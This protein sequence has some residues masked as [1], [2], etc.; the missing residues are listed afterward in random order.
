L[1]WKKKK[2]QKMEKINAR[3]E[4]G[5]FVGIKRASGEVWVATPEGIMKARSVKRIPK[6]QRWGPDCLKWVKH[7]PW[8][9]YPGATDADGEIPEDKLVEASGSTGP[10]LGG[11]AGRVM[12]NVRQPPPREFY[13]RKEDG[14]KHGYTKGCSGCSS[15]FR[16]LGR[17]PHSKAC[18]DRFRELLKGEAKMKNAE[19]RKQEFE[20]KVARKAEKKEQKKEEK[21]KRKAGEGGG[22]EDESAMGIADDAEGM[23]RVKKEMEAANKVGCRGLRWEEELEKIKQGRKRRQ[24]DQGGPE[25]DEEMAVEFEEED[26]ETEEETRSRLAEKTL[27]MWINEVA[28]EI[29]DEE[30]MELENGLTAW[31]DVHGD[32]LDMKL[33]RKGR[34]EEIDYMEFRGIWEVCDEDEAWRETGHGPVSTKWVDTNKGTKEE[35]LVRCRLVARDFRKKGEKDREDLF[36]ATPPLETIRILLSKAATRRPNKKKKKLM[37]IDAKKAH[38]NPEC[39]DKVYIKLPEECG[40]EMGKCGRLKHWLYGFRPAAQAWENFYAEKLEK[41]G[42]QRG[43]A[44]PVIFRNEEKDMDCVVHGDDFTLCGFDEDLRWL[45]EEMAK[46][47]EIKVRAILGDDDKDDKEIT[48]LG[49]IIRWKDWGIEYQADPKH[50]ELV[51]QKL[52]FDEKTKVLTVNGEKNKAEKDREEYDD[53]EVYGE[54]ATSFRAIAARLNFLAM[55]SPDIM[56]PVKEICREMSRPKRRSWRAIKR[57]A[58]YMLGRK[59]V[60]WRYEWQSDQEVLRVYADSDWAGCSRTRKSTSGGCI[61]LGGH[62]L[63]AWSS[64]QGGIALSSAEAE[65]YAMVD[66]ATR[67]FGIKSLAAELGL[68]INVVLHTDSSGA[69]SMASRRGA[70]RVRHI[71]TKWL[72]LQAAVA[73]GLIKL[74][75]VAGTVNPADLMTKFLAMELIR[76]HLGFCGCGFL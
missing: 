41:V 73:N 47:F 53:Q 58:R 28:V 3:W 33:V 74:E 45:A 54:E 48:L 51:L 56:Y 11:A 26:S 35:P 64:T 76:R 62:L 4:Y 12:I 34:K 6:E 27:K 49:R 43:E 59:A 52:G 25:Q 71:E 40:V 7:A 60:V 38:I 16:G 29:E 68:K 39:K 42:F 37:F 75:K 57:L 5:I 10:L 8:N 17:Q 36:A 1:F 19:K 44:S 63:K 22:D 13:I 24:E 72:W 21:R 69:K 61:M 66:A 65:Y 20:E 30:D 15:W 14:E 31:D 46:W 32:E 50:R 67:G 18:R 9:R 70:G 23:K 2:G 55:D